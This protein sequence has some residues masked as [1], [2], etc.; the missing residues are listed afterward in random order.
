MIQEKLDGKTRGR[1]WEVRRKTGLEETGRQPG[2]QTNVEFVFSISKRRGVKGFE[3]WH[4][5]YFSLL[6]GS[7]ATG[8]RILLAESGFLKACATL[9]HRRMTVITRIDC[10]EGWETWKQEELGISTGNSEKQRSA[11]PTEPPP[12]GRKSWP[13]DLNHPGP[14]GGALDFMLQ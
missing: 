6:L 13:V 4:V 11:V 8:D 1:I 3:Q 9:K 10:R 7:M 14:A 12:K 2:S 5:Q